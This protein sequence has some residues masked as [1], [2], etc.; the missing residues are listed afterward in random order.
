MLAKVRKVALV[1]AFVASCAGAE[2]SPAVSAPRDSEPPDASRPELPSPPEL[3]T[4]PDLVDGEDTPLADVDAPW[5]D[6]GQPSPDLSVAVDAADDATGSAD[7]GPELCGNAVLDPGE[8]CDLGLDDPRCAFCAAL[9][10]TTAHQ[11]FP[12]VRSLSR[13]TSANGGVALVMD[14]APARLTG[15]YEHPY[16]AVD[17]D[18]PTR[19]LAF[20]A[21]V[22]WRSGALATASEAGGW[23][24]AVPP[25]S[26]EYESGTGLIRLV[27]TVG[28]LRFTTWVFAPLAQ[29][30]RAAVLLVRVENVGASAV[31]VSVHALWNLHLGGKGSFDGEL[32]ATEPG[33]KRLIET[34][35]GNTVLYEAFGD[36]DLFVTADNGGGANNPF[37]LM[38]SRAPLGDSVETV[39][40][41]DIAVGLERRLGPIESMGSRWFG[42]VARLGKTFDDPPL[43]ASPAAWLEAERAGWDAWHAVEP[44]L[45][46]ATPAEAALFR[47]ATAQLRMGQV[48][49]LDA[50]PSARC[51]G[52]L[53]ASLPPGQWHITW[54]RD[55]VYAMLAL[56]RSGHTPEARAGLDFLAGALVRQD[57]AEPY[58]QRR[59]IES[60]DKS[61]GVWGLGRA[62]D[63]ELGLSLARYFGDGV[64]ESDSNAA[65]PNL[66]F[67]NL[68]LF[69]VGFAAVAE[70]DL[71]A[72]DAHWAF[73]TERVADILIQLGTPAGTGVL[74]LPDSSIWERHFCPH[75]QCP[76]PETRKRHAYSSLVAAAGLARVA[77]M[78]ELRGDDARAAAYG[79]FAEQLR[80]G[81]RTLHKAPPGALHPA[82]AGNVEELPFE[83]YYLDAAALEA[84][85]L[86]VVPPGA[87][88]AFGTA[89]ALEAS[90]RVGAHSPGYKRNDD[91]TWYDRQEWVFI[92]LRVASALHRMGQHG[93]AR[94][95]LDWI[96]AVGSANAGVIPELLSDGVWEPGTEDA[97]GD[98]GGLAQG[99]WPMVG[100]GAGA[101][102]LALTELLAN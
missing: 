99:A 75:G 66:E 55:Q 29:A 30:E 42:A 28:T 72:G 53:L 76:E 49:A 82:L 7:A 14:T 40:P 57:G 23:L 84:V 22:G 85:N 12:A 86:G 15:L 37:T 35:S 94:T 48:T 19:Q 58:Y 79:A 54:V 95:L 98:P 21:Y 36:G 80:L 51:A 102:V 33:T 74:L 62:I 41:G 34:R 31:P 70:Q 88:E 11:A 69:L 91:P 87:V 60:T 18:T 93:R 89:D 81:L 68:G 92:D 56:L 20:D 39:N 38:Q 4:L 44:A 83:T 45:P 16:K 27:Q 1:L 61:P 43:E 63:G 67:D 2:S 71:T 46:G 78:A 50:C 73:A 77:A 52:Q 64:E 25:D 65:G 100:F 9:V 6:V 3:P 17:G 59:F 32:A 26:A 97:L 47:T 90:L 13:L 10:D 24:D 96:T 101:Y 5:D 8:A